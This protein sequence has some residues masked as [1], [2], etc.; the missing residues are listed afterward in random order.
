M[1]KKSLLSSCL[2][3]VNKGRN[4]KTKCCLVSIYE[5]DSSYFLFPFINF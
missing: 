3:M 2:N 4:E 1:E 5:N